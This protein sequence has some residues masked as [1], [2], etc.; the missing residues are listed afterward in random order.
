MNQQ[1]RQKYEDLKRRFLGIEE[2]FYAAKR[3]EVRQEED[4]ISKEQASIKKGKDRQ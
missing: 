2:D 3:K 4:R 1:N